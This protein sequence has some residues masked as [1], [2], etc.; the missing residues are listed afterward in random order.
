MQ[1][2]VRQLLQCTRDGV[3]RR[4]R[5]PRQ[6][7][8][9]R[10]CRHP[11]LQRSVARRARPSAH[12]PPVPVWLTQPSVLRAASASCRPGRIRRPRGFLGSNVDVGTVGTD[13]HRAGRRERLTVGAR[14]AET[15]LRH[16]AVGAAELIDSAGC[17]VAG[18]DRKPVVAVLPMF[19]RS[20]LAATAQAPPNALPRAHAPPVPVVLTQP[21]KPGSWVN[22]PCVSERAEPED[23]ATANTTVAAATM[24]LMRLRFPP[25]PGPKHGSRGGAGFRRATAPADLIAG[26]RG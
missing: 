24:A 26:L 25:S 17:P 5:L 6:T 7:P 22:A 2:D 16:A 4:R 14:P 18:E 23:A 3:T 11:S 10:S 20:G 1:P 21:S 19:D 13:S 8:R 15:A 9:R 12:S